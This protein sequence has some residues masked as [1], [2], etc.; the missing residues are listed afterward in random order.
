MKIICKYNNGKDLPEDLFKEGSGS[1]EST[2]FNVIQGRQYTV[3]GMTIWHNYMWYYIADEAYL[4]YPRWNPAPL[5]DVVDNRLSKYWVFSFQRGCN[6]SST[7]TSIVF[8]EWANDPY[9][10]DALTDGEEQA[11]E[12]F[13]KYK[14]LMD[15]EFPDTTV[16]AKY[17]ATLSSDKQ[18]FICPECFESWASQ[19]SDGMVECPKCKLILHNPM[20][21]R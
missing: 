11:V 18:W 4:Y 16:P 6:E 19:S 12:L 15:V 7:Y 9:Y 13:K 2:Q 14:R 21:S 1:N 3:Y 8:P 5:F 20:F 10:Y 17:T